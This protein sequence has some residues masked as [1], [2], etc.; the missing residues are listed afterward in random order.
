MKVKIAT[1]TNKNV[2]QRLKSFLIFKK[3]QIFLLNI[4]HPFFEKIFNM[5][6]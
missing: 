4:L 1:P 5:L 6:L 3:L 2:K